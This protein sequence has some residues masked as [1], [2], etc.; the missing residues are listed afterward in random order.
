LPELNNLGYRDESG[1][2]AMDVLQSKKGNLKA[3]RWVPGIYA[4]GNFTYFFGKKKKSGVSI[5][6]NFSSLSAEYLLT[7]PV[8]YTYKS[9]DGNDHYRRQITISKLDE[10]INTSIYNIPLMYN[11]RAYFNAKRELVVSFKIGPSLMV[12]NGRSNYNATI[13][14][15]GIYQVDTLGKDKITYYDHFD[16]GS[17]YN[18]YVNS[19]GINNQNTNPGAIAVFSQLPKSVDFVSNKN[20]VG[21][22][23]LVRTTVGFNLALQGQY[24]I[25]LANSKGSFLSM[26]FAGHF[27]YAPFFDRKNNYKPIERTTDDYNSIY[28]S[29]A[30]SQYMA[31]GVTVGFVYNL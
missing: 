23:N 4:G 22:Q 12:F 27:V 21:R 28:T 19:T 17:T 2:D 5:G 11:Y 3:N 15:G 29:S 31:Y 1:N 18:V 16:A 24:P 9:F 10:Q 30:R 13:D 8:V 14:V 6:V 26:K 7:S 25:T 20:Y